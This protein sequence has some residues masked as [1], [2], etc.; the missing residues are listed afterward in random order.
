MG[1]CTYQLL[2]TV[3]SAL[4]S[5]CQGEE[6]EKL[7]E[8]AIEV[9]Q[10]PENELKGKKLLGGNGIGFLDIVGT[11]AAYWMPT[12]QEAVGKQLITKE[13][14]PAM[15]DWAQRLLSCNVIQENLPP[16][17]KLLAFYIPSS[18]CSYACSCC[19]LLNPKR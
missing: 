16:K 4:Y 17:E 12:L 13:N 10:P 3:E 19:C 8:E 14:Y 18:H 6:T 5:T 15:C 11:I 2:P 7:N 1:W 9:L